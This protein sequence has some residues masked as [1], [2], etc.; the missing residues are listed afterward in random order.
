[1]Q[2]DTLGVWSTGDA[3]LLERADDGVGRATSPASWR[4]ERIEGAG[5]L[6][7][8]STQPER[9]N[10]LLLDFLAVK[11]A[12]ELRA[13]FAARELSPVET[14]RRR[15]RARR[16]RRL[17]HAHARDAPASRP[18]APSGPT[19]TA[20]RARSKGLTLAVKDLFDT[21][22]VRT[23]YGSRDLRRPRPDGR[24]RRRSGG[25]RTRARSSSARRSRTSSPGASP[26]T[27]RTSRRAATRGTRSASR[28]A[29][30]AAPAV[31]LATGAGGA[32]ARHATPAARSAS[33]PR[34]AA[35]PA[36]SRPTTGSRRT[37]VFPLARSLDHAGPMART[38]ADVRL[39][40][41]GADRP[42]ATADAAQRIAVCP[43]LHAARARARHPARVR[44][45]RRSARRRRRR[46]RLRGGRAD[47]PGVRRDPGRR[48]RARP[49]RPVPARAGTSTART[50]RRAS[51]APR[52][53]TLDGLRR[54]D[55]DA[56]ADPRG[57]SRACSPPADLLLT[58]IAGAAAGADA[59]SAR[60]RFRDGVLPLHG[61]AGRR[62]PAVV[63]RARR[64]RRPRPAGRRA[65]HRPAVER[66]PRAR[67]RRARCSARQHRRGR[68]P[69]RPG[70]LRDPHP[71]LV[72]RSTS[73]SPRPAPAS[74]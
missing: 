34:S 12:V 17:R 74:G 16:A 7:A 14:D 53:V 67:R 26:P 2:A 52:T 55:R 30:A 21:E 40:L 6:D 22:G 13:A 73:T 31:A 1:M 37:G 33:R 41:R 18:S 47:L 28:A 49:R 54:G 61:P 57:A 35:S 46:G 39:L 4:Y 10:A 44:R 3:F 62:R 27:T 59:A 8:C 63:R 65:A 24:R 43:D 19:R 58:P 32:R 38:P 50:S 68:D 69:R 64:L 5:P 72:A 29:R 71:D 9:V 45:R 36:S 15:R 56:R 23:T 20:P 42:R 25:P 60:R 66:G 51:S 11:T 48:G 70:D